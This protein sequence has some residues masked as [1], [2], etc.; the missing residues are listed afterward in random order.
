M[1]PVVDGP[2]ARPA[3]SAVRPPCARDALQGPQRGSGAGHTVREVVVPM[4][5]REELGTAQLDPPLA[6]VTLATM[7]L[8]PA[9]T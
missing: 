6:R 2:Q 1:A 5:S 7:Q 4:P 8:D 9:W 3:V